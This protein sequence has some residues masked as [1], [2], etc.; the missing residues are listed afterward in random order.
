MCFFQKRL[1]YFALIPQFLYLAG[2]L[3]EGQVIG[4]W[5]VCCFHPG[6]DPDMRGACCQRHPDRNHLWN[7]M[8]RAS[9]PSVLSKARQHVLTRSAP[10]D[11]QCCLPTMCRISLRFLR[12]RKLASH[13]LQCS[14]GPE[15]ASCGSPILHNLYLL[16]EE[17]NHQRRC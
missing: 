5:C 1:Y 3:P 8:G 13:H 9:A 7:P 10:S 12:D 16:D 2:A 6:H 15:L 14:F 4:M 11:F 17:G